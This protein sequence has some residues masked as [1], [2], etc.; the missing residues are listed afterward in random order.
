MKA[1]RKTTVEPDYEALA[2][3]DPVVQGTLLHS[4]VVICVSY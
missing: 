1:G 2:D 4:I 3:A